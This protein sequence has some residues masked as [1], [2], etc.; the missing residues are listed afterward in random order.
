MRKSLIWLLV[1]F[2]SSTWELAVGIGRHLCFPPAP[3]WVM[4]GDVWGAGGQ[5]KVTLTDYPPLPSFASVF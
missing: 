5:G 3:C 1:A 2:V 4:G